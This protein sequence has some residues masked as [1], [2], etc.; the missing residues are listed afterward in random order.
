MKK[1]NI[2]GKADM[3]GIFCG[4]G[5]GRV[6]RAI[7]LC[8]CFFLLSGLYAHPS[9]AAEVFSTIDTDA[10]NISATEM[11][12]TVKE[13]SILCGYSET[14]L[15]RSFFYTDS[16]PSLDR[17]TAGFP[18][19]LSAVSPSGTLIDVPVIW[20]CAGEDYESSASRYFQFVPVPGEGYEFSAAYDA[21]LDAPYIAVFADLADDAD[22]FDTASVPAEGESDTASVPAVSAEGGCEEALFDASSAVKGENAAACFKYFTK[23]MSLNAAAACGIMANIM[24]ES[25][26]NPKAKGDNGTSY[27]ICQWHDDP[28]RGYTRWSDLKSYCDRNDLDWHTI[29][30]QLQY[31]GYEAE[32]DYPRTMA[33]MRSVTND[34]DGAWDA[35]DCWCRNYEVPANK[36]EV[37]K[38]RGNLARDTFWPVYGGRQQ[39]EGKKQEEEK[40]PEE[41]I[42]VQNGQDITL[43]AGRKLNIADLCFGE[44]DIKADRYRIVKKYQKYATVTKAGKLTAKKK[45]Q[46]VVEARQAVTNSDGKTEY[47]T[48]A[49]A[50]INVVKKPALKI[51]KMTDADVQTDIFE[52]FS[53]DLGGIKPD[54]I[55]SSKPAV[56]TVSEDGMLAALKNGKSKITVYF[57]EPGKSGTV[58]VSATVKVKLKAK[59]ENPDE[60]DTGI[61]QINA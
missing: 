52:C 24:A 48:V 47:V 35:G 49:Q 59:T 40:Q 57:G 5:A 36:I 38:T 19:K 15:Y 11:N 56:V 4:R 43:V 6:L 2:P 25:S 18:D 39:E 16:K 10:V 55:K 32:K 34:A 23:E 13:G 3:R 41:V 29:D 1:R 14:G 51:P 7:S 20:I 9:F 37:G 21:V 22:V 33:R 8:V 17:L 12:K 28:N 30:G 44:L 42:T 58:A 50:N 45:G 60:T 61:R 27:G 46:A 54:M 53:T 26:F 31:L